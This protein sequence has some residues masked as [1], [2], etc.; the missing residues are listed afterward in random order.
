M[1]HPLKTSIRV[2]VSALLKTCLAAL[3]L[4]IPLVAQAATGGFDVEAATRAYTDTLQGDARAQSDA[5]FE[6][7]YWLILWGAV[8]GILGEWIILRTGLSARFRDWAERRTSRR[9][10]SPALYALPYAIISSLI[11][12]PWT[13][14]TG[15]V[16]EQQY[17][18]MNLDFGSWL[19]EQAIGLVIGIVI[20]ALFL[21][22]LFAVI[23]RAQRLWWIW[24]TA[25]VGAFIVI[26]T[27]VAPVFISPLFNTY[28]PM[29][30]GPLRTSILAM[31]EANDVP[32]DNVY[33]FDQSRQ[34]D[35]ISANVSGMFGT[36]RISLNDNLL[37]RTSPEEV[38]AVMGHELG[39]YVLNHGLIL[40]TVMTAIFGLGF[41]LVAK[42]TPA[43]LARHGSR[44]GIRGVDD[45]AAFPVFVIV[46]TAY[47]FVMT[48]ALNSLIRIVE[49][50][51]DAF[52]LEAARQPDG[53]AAVAMR[54]SEYRKI[55]PSALEEMIF[56]DHP[57]GRTRVRMSMDWKA[58]NVDNPQL[59]DPTALL[60]ETAE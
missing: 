54:L 27:V 18:L 1:A 53:F 34:H 9:W 24:A 7:G 11:V 57:S 15:F 43:I 47:L 48:P 51:A 55:E 59:V 58:A 37:E 23:R 46:L 40:I 42:L 3:L 35:R 16:R 6:G 10:L 21:M 26:G 19:S 52:G 12:F 25:V 14:Y 32:A 8:V 41:F 28:E 22:A 5:Y 31:A 2:P 49:S 36:M 33:V 50:Q 38:E 39:H 20:T 60:T 45:P 4:S 13:I 29:A 17:E 56:F 44:W 30:D